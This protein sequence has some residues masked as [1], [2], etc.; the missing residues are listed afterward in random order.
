MI[1]Q[2]ESRTLLSAWATFSSDPGGSSGAALELGSLSGV[3]RYTDSLSP[4]DRADYLKFEVA[5]R[6]NFNITLSGLKS[7]VDVQLL[8]SNG[9]VLA[10]SDNGGKHAERISRFINNGSYL[11]RIY[12][13]SG[14]KSSPYRIALQADLNWG[15]IGNGSNQKDISLVFAN[16]SSQPISRK[17]ETWILIHGWSAP[18]RPIA[19]T[20][21]ADAVDKNSRTDQVLLLDWSDAA[22]TTNVFDAA[23]WTPAVAQWA[24]DKLASWGISASKIN[25]M[26]HSLGGLVAD[27]LSSEISGG[28]NKIV[29]LDPATDIPGTSFSGVDFA[30]D[31]RYSVAFVGS[32][33]A[34]VSAAATA[35]ETFQMNVGPKDSLVTHSNV[36]DLLAS[37]IV[38]STR[39]RPDAVSKFF[40]LDKLTPSA[41][42]PFAK[43]AFNGVYEGII[44]GQ[45]KG[46]AW[47]PVKLTY[48]NKAGKTVVV[49]A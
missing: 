16:D 11:I 9:Q 38:S 18:G 33:Y 30:A 45:L 6:G 29:A 34:T 13:G 39:R 12:A 5:Y 26:G 49:T 48:K 27:R 40:D 15:K 35:D 31:S 17:K 24:A 25:L 43:N 44:D 47:W 42:P 21:L 28:V 32:N 41:K 7:N 46:D 23:M 10:T 20:R 14:F 4:K 37:I 3:R 36:V 22:S 8:N 2:L 1:E 19:L